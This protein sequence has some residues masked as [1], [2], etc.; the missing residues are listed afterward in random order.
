ME[1]TESPSFSLFNLDSWL[2]SSD[3]RVVWAGVSISTTLVDRVHRAF[4]GLASSMNV[5]G[6]PLTQWLWG[7]D[8]AAEEASRDWVIVGR[9]RGT[10]SGA[11][12]R[13]PAPHGFHDVRV[14]RFSWVGNPF[15]ASVTS[16]A[17]LAFDLLTTLALLHGAADGTAHLTWPLEDSAFLP[18]A[19]LLERELLGG[20][21][22]LLPV[23]LAS[24]PHDLSI[25]T[26]LAWLF[27]HARLL[28]SGQ[29]LRLL[30]WCCDE[31][32]AHRAWPHKCH[33]QS[34][35]TTLL[36]LAWQL[37]GRPPDGLRMAAPSV[38]T[39][40]PTIQVHASPS[41]HSGAHFLPRTGRSAR[42]PPGLASTT[43][44][45]VVALGP[46]SHCR[47]CPVAPERCHTAGPPNPQ[48]QLRRDS[49]VALRLHGA[50]AL[51]HHSVSRDLR[52]HTH[53]R[54]LAVCKVDAPCLRHRLLK[55]LCFCTAHTL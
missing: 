50:Y 8:S 18:I 11:V 29:R 54:R 44:E 17:C 10:G 13:L 47:G 14:D 3:R 46:A 1:G 9:L 32:L 31:T 40:F 26:L 23:R 53:L 33:A 55:S 45:G 2:R 36:W 27:A 25:A 24:G 43:A 39:G 37:N 38:M 49:Q 5:C 52:L 6:S 28:A 21:R 16:D 7:E 22:R 30:C 19:G 41:Y 20:V 34:L 35:A 15:K 12:P 48:R 42:Q 51:I 4:A